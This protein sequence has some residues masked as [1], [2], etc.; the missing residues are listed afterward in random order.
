MKKLLLIFAVIIIAVIIFNLDQ[1]KKQE[2]KDTILAQKDTVTEQVESYKSRLSGSENDQSSSD[3]SSRKS[4]PDQRQKEPEW[5]ATVEDISSFIQKIP[6]QRLKETFSKISISEDS[7]KIHQD[8][9]RFAIGLSRQVELEAMEQ[10]RQHIVQLCDQIIATFEQ[11]DIDYATI[12]KKVIDVNWNS[13][14]EKNKQLAR[15]SNYDQLK[16][17]YLEQAINIKNKYR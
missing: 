11:L 12:E 3:I 6:E 14:A 17:K 13:P 9:A 16:N 4:T 7:Y 5:K 15:L 8:A 2:L 1:E 10:Q